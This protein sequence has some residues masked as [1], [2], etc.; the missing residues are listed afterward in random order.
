M[1]R[2]FVLILITLTVISSLATTFL[3]FDYLNRQSSLRETAIQAAREQAEQSANDISDAFSD[4]MAIA[5][6]LA[7][8]LTT[9]A[10]PY[11][12][13]DQRL[14]NE[15]LMRPDID[16]LAITFEPFVYDSELELY[17]SYIFKTEN[18]EFDTLVGASYDYTRPPDDNPN[19]PNTDWYYYT[20]QD[21]ARW[22]E[23]FFATGAQKVLVE[24]GVPFYID[25]A[26][27]EIAGIVTIDYSLNDVSELIDELQLGSTG[28]GFVISAQGTLLAHPVS[29]YV[30]RQSIFDIS[31]DEML[32]ESIQEAITGNSQF[33][34][35]VDAVTG[36]KTWQFFEPIGTTGWT[37]GIVLNQDEFLLTQ[38]QLIQEQ[39]TIALSGAITIFFV[40]AT[41]FYFDGFRITGL[42]AAS[43]TFSIL[44]VAL[45]ILIWWIT[46]DLQTNAGLS[47]TDEVQLDRYLE[48]V[49]QTLDP[50]D[51][52]LVIPTG[53]L[54]QAMQFPEP[55]SVTIN[56]YIW[57]HYPVGHEIQ[58][59]F[60]LPQR[61]GE[62]ATIEQV[63]HEIN[64][65]TE[66]FVWYI[67]VTIRQIY[68]V[69]QFPFDNRN[70]N[71]RLAPVDLRA[72]IQLSPDFGSY[73]FVNP[74][75]LPGIDT[76]VSIN[77]WHFVSSRFSYDMQQSNIDLR[78]NDINNLN[79]P[80]L[81][82]SIQAQRNYLGPFIAY[83]LPGVIA[84]AMMFTYLVAKHQEGN[85]E[86]IVGALNY[87]A[88]LF[89]VVAVIHTGLRAQIAAVGITYL[90]YVYILL[91][92][93]IVLVSANVFLVARYADWSIVRYRSNIIPKLLYWPVFTGALLVITLLIFVYT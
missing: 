3:T 91:Y 46:N 80:E 41:I 5:D 93:A 13:I 20:V 14:F 70:I 59:G 36:I 60:S 67:G 86:E 82:F 56:G 50:T 55:T 7:N 40:L 2:L 45:I 25:D 62:E 1:Q 48:S 89:F 66:T 61:I 58:A 79:L 15:A 78:L 53:I 49:N 21:G 37:V 12:S 68:D 39:I 10:Q 90:E 64:E 69:T 29:D 16:G 47:I 52:P 38:Q 83:L 85:E 4:V 88:A 24:Y 74:V 92:L 76:G 72:N 34:D 81:S 35:T 32:E 84:A 6:D 87:A 51:K 27:E 42:W 44:C 22:M 54:I 19:T 18:G 23:P 30:V 65:E 57:Q 75:S 77:N 11:E 28:Y 43:N 73:N 26:N 71:I 9:G 17:Q 31:D 33:I 63:H 8:D